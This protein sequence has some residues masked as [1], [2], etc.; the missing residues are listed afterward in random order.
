MSPLH[1]TN[2]SK[3]IKYTYFRVRWFQSFH[4]LNYSNLS[5]DYL[6]FLQGNHLNAVAFGSPPLPVLLSSIS[7]H[8]LM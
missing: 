1:R 6:T 2:K 4:C 3:P 5:T 8:H 7:V